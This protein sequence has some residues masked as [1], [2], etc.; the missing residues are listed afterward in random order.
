MIELDA[1]C[2]C[3]LGLNLN[4]F[5]SFHVIFQNIILQKVF[6]GIV[7]TS[8]RILASHLSRINGS[9]LITTHVY[10][11]CS[12]IN[13][14]RRARDG[15]NSHR[16]GFSRSIRKQFYFISIKKNYAILLMCIRRLLGGTLQYKQDLVSV[17]LYGMNWA[18]GQKWASTQLT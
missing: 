6:E 11:Y 16:L 1:K 18:R 12:V 13:Q 17:Y 2:T 7:S 15:S 4:Y 10:C 8:H 14:S 5:Q 9:N 3:I